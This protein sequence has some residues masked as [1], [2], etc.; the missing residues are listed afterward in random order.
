[1]H[2][3]GQ[4]LEPRCPSSRACLVLLLC[5]PVRGEGSPRHVTTEQASICFLNGRRRTFLCGEVFAF[6]KSS[7]RH[8]K[9]KTDSVMELAVFDT[10]RQFRSFFLGGDIFLS[11]VFFFFFGLATKGPGLGNVCMGSEKASTIWSFPHQISF[12]FFRFLARLFLQTYSHYQYNKG[13]RISVCCSA[14]VRSVGRP[15]ASFSIWI[16]L[17]F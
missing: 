6:A 1:M 3:K 4:G 11:P 5:F 10:R 2:K 16:Q 8:L 13:L 15:I 7:K 17:Q 14:R 9:T 12:S